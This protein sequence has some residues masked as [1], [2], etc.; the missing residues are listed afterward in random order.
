MKRVPKFTRLLTNPEDLKRVMKAR[1][2]FSNKYSNGRLLII[3]GSHEY[4]GAPVIAFSA[5][6]Q[7]LAALRAGAGYA[8]AFVPNSI[9]ATART[10]SP[11]TIIEGLGKNDIV[12]EK[13]LKVEIEKADAIVIG[14]GMSRKSL[15]TIAKIISYAIERGK[16]VVADA[17]A[18]E[19]IKLVRN[20]DPKNLVIT[21]HDG[22]FQRLAGLKVPIRDAKGRIKMAKEA[23]KKYRSTVVLKGHYTI[24]TDG[25][26]AKLNVPKTAALA[27]MGTG[28][29]LSGMIG[30][31]AAAGAGLFE[32][33]VAAV[34]LHSKIGDILR[35]KLRYHIIATDI[36][37]ILNNIL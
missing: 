25:T 9:L 2:V 35:N 30:G 4:Y 21:P 33:S 6:R 27:T 12:F 23:S 13:S 26:R 28:D 15:T 18:I 34:Y 16:K 10:L 5:G 8:K 32:A 24:I 1:E 17:E 29:V 20:R 7:S 36:I 14:M 22:E 31:Y 37:D 11:N 3:G 19:A